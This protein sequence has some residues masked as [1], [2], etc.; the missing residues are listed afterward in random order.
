M[1]YVLPHSLSP[2]PPKKTTQVVILSNEEP[3]DEVRK[4]K[5]KRMVL[6]VK[7]T[8]APCSNNGVGM[9]WVSRSFF[10]SSLFSW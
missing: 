3:D 1:V 8:L 7:S 5:G 6:C 10:L 9:M 4:E 2:P